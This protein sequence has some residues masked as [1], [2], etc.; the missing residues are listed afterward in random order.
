M[1]INQNGMFDTMAANA[2]NPNLQRIELG[3]IWNEWQDNWVGRPVEGERR[4]IGGVIREQQFRNGA[5]RRLLQRQEIT[6]VQQV[7]QTR[8]GVRQVMVPQVVRNSLGDRVLNVA[9]IPFIRSRTINFTGTRFKPNTRLFAFFDNIDINTY[10]TP[11]GGSLGGNI[12]SDAN[13]A[14]SG[15]FAIPDATVDSNPRWRTGTRVFRLTSSSTNDRVSD[16]ETAGEADYTA[17]GTLETVRE[18]IVSTREPRLVRENTNETRT[19]ARTSTRTATRQVGWWD[20]LAQTFLV[21][22]PGGDFLTSIDLFFQSKPGA[23]ESQVPVTVQLREVQNGYPS[24]T[25]LP[26]SEVTLNPS[27]VNVSEDASVATTFTFPSPVYI[28]ENVEYCFVVLANTQEYNMW[29]SRVGQTNKGTDRTISQ[30]PYNGVLFKS[31]NGS[32]W[33]AEQNEDAKFKIKRAEFSNVTGV[34]TF[35]NDS[36]PVR[37]LAT[38][39]IRTTSGSHVIRVSHPNHGM[40]GTSNNVTIAGLDGSTSY[41]GILGSSI[42]GTYTSISNVTLDSYEVNIADST[43]AEIQVMLVVHL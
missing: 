2:G 41:N 42:N 30:Q 27:S 8:T 35:C 15:T 34:A 7:N 33:T 19:I 18:T 16:I 32:T 13:G 37:T 26:F 24:T 20:P 25:I 36:L 29:I 5:P 12:V 28:Q 11:T 17:R 39:P 23:S 21:D 22:D 4:N 3:T 10:V 6:T 31:Q 38:N 40:H 14:V 43:T 1:V 9:F